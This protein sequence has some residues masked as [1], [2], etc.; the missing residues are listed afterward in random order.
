MKT[1]GFIPVRG[2]SKS[3]PLKNIKK[4][5]YRP[6]LFWAL[7]AAVDSELNEVYVY[8]D[9]DEIKYVVE[10]DYYNNEKIKVIDR[11]FYT[12]TDTAS[13]EVCLLD[14][15]DRVEFDNIVL[16]QATSPL[17]SANDI[18]KSIELLFKG[19]YDSVLS[20]VKQKR[21]LWQLDSDYKA[22]AINYD[23]Y[24]RPRRQEF[25][26]YYVENGALYAT[27]KE[28]LRKSKN[29]ISGKIGIVEMDEYAYNEIDEPSDWDIVEKLIEIKLAKN[30]KK[31]ISKIKLFVLDIDGVMTDAG[32]YY[33]LEGEFLKKFNTRDAMG[34]EILKNNGV[35]I[36]VITSEISE[37][38][39]SRMNKLN[40]KQLY[41]GKKD[42]LSVLRSICK[43]KGLGLHEVAYIGD[44][45]NDIPSLC[46]SGLSF[47]PQNSAEEVKKYADI[48]LNHNG[49]EGAI[50]EACDYILKANKR[51]ED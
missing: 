37:I 19:K 6:L 38:N 10:H 16:I 15:L 11:P 5:F 48:I 18:N 28:C 49:G 32:M 14:F 45:I 39:I 33:N 3:I 13:T 27:K 7:D 34:L 4:L 40:I 25:N 43:Q 35:E 46:C 47:V 51:L 31:T 41:S 29:R 9:S 30:Y 17:I 36:S 21:F 20:V 50:R 12:S 44:D 24:Q 2:G 26:G 23:P 22:I 1:V 42:K 8:T